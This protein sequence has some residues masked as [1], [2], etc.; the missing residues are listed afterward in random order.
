V[1]AAIN[2]VAIKPVT[3]TSS[4]D[5]SADAVLNTVDDQTRVIFLCS[6][7]NPSGN[8]MSPD[9]I[10]TIIKTFNGLVVVDEAYID[11]TDVP[12]ISKK[13]ADFP[14]LIVLQTL[15]KAWG[16]AGIRLGMAYDH[17]EIIALLNKIKP[18]YNISSPSQ[19]IAL[20]T[21]TRVA[22]KENR[23]KEILQERHR[24]SL[25]LSTTRCVIHVYPSQ[26]N[27]VLVKVKDASRAYKYLVGKGVVVR[28][29]SQVQLCEDCL[30]ITIGTQRENDVLLSALSSYE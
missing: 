30:R 13:L 18:P 29:R 2:D 14:N 27:F 17:P 23:V 10:K 5:L 3:L 6:P 7:N 28:D 8:L 1:S 24:V 26:A 16:L 9:A 4:F 12:S 21:L 15:S 20:D 11:F 19:R 22:E 25:T